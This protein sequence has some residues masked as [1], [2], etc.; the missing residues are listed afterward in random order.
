M[1]GK[2]SDLFFH[3]SVIAF[4]SKIEAV[5]SPDKI[6][7][8]IV[9]IFR[10]SSKGGEL[11]KLLEGAQFFRWQVLQPFEIEWVVSGERVPS[12]NEPQFQGQVN[13]AKVTNWRNIATDVAAN[14]VETGIDEQ[15]AHV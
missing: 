6:K 1:I 4:I 12:D 5:Q 13:E 14:T 9:Y 7:G 8:L 3:R 15:T 10:R 11:V 2:Y